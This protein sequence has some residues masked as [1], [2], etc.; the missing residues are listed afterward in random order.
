MKRSTKFAG[1]VAAVAVA[2]ILAAGSAQ[3]DPGTV[4]FS[5]GSMNCAIFA[6]GSLGCD[7]A[8]PLRLSYYVGDT[9]V[10]VPVPV[11]EIAIDQPWLPAH[12]TFDP[13]TPYTLPGGNPSIY[14]VRTG[15]GQWGPIVEHAGASCQ[16]GF[17]GSF[18]CQALGRGFTSYG[19]TVVA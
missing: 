10:P 1:A 19:G 6:D 4:Y 5:V 2:P 7:F 16:V 17:H 14:D 12:P 15:S 13:A 18:T 3:A 9:Y 8:A 11:N